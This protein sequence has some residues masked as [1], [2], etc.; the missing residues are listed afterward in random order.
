MQ[1]IYWRVVLAI[2]AIVFVL[3]QPD[4]HMSNRIFE[5]EKQ[6]QKISENLNVKDIQSVNNIEKDLNKIN[7]ELDNPISLSFEE[8]ELY[9]TTLNDLLQETTIISKENELEPTI[10]AT[11]FECLLTVQEKLQEIDVK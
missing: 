4:A 1:K 8:Y 11:K 9:Q 10:I 5:L 7:L 2:F 3:A 6:S